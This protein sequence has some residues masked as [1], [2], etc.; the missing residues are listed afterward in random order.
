[1]LWKPHVDTVIANARSDLV[2]VGGGVNG[3]GLRSINSHNGHRGSRNEDRKRKRKG[4]GTEGSSCSK[5]NK[6]I[7]VQE[8]IPK[9][10]RK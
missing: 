8:V 5:R 9:R 7:C 6:S 3:R 2:G 4:G 10:G 1:M